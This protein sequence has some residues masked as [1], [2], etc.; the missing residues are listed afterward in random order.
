MESKRELAE[1]MQYVIHIALLMGLTLKISSNYRDSLFDYI[2]V[3][4]GA[5][6]QR[7]LI[8]TKLPLDEIFVSLG[9]AMQ[10][11]GKI[12]KCV[13]INSVLSVW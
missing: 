2:V 3:F 13:E 12:T 9:D 7:V 4:N 11:Y 6:T 5:N 10:H 8:D 1:K